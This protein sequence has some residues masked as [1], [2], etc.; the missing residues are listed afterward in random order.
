[1]GLKKQVPDCYVTP[2]VHTVPFNILYQPTDGP[3][4]IQ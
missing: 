1:M 3:N 4:E 2:T